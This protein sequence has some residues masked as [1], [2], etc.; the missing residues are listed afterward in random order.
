MDTDFVD[1]F[2]QKSDALVAELETRAQF[3]EERNL[4]YGRKT[5]FESIGAREAS[6]K[7]IALLKGNPEI[8]DRTFFIS[9][10]N[11]LFKTVDNILRSNHGFDEFDLQN[12]LGMRRGYHDVLSMW[13]SYFA[14]DADPLEDLHEHTRRILSLIPGH[15]L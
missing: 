4:V 6:D 13:D 8:E 11:E 9:P 10:A 15:Q 5:S 12:A 2:I 14:T 3:Y 7:V 1:R